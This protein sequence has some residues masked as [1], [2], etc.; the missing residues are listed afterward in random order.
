MIKFDN[1]PC[2]PVSVHLLLIKDK[3]ILMLKRFNTG[4]E[5]GSFSTIAGKLEENESVFDCG[6]REAKEE[7]NVSVK[8]VSVVHVM[9]RKGIDSNRIDF[10]LLA[11]EWF[12]SL[13]NNE[14]DKCSMIQWFYYNELP[15]NTIQ[16]VKYALYEIQKGNMF[17]I[18]G[19]D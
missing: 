15:A 6:I 11:K 3:K 2:F 13:S 18:Y 10:F 16:Y 7:V 9:N 5:D 17:S 14:P 19:W 4:F 1:I 8:T 12:G